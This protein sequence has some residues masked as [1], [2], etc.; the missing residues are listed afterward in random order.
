MFQA[1]GFT[2]HTMSVQDVAELAA[3]AALDGAVA[4]TG[5]VINATGGAVPD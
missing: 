2:D 5:T 3:R 1:R 4:I